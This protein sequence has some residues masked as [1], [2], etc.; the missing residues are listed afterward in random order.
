MDWSKTKTIFIFTFLILNIFL[1]YHLVE[2]RNNS[3]LDILTETS[4]EEKFEVDEITYVDLPK[5]PMRSSFVTGKSKFFTEDEVELLETE[6]EQVVTIL[7]ETKLRGVFKEPFAF[8]ETN[9]ATR[10]DQIIKNQILY[11]DQYVYWGIN[12]ES[13]A[14]IYFQKYDGRIIFNNVSGSLRLYLNDD[15]EIES[16]EQTYIDEMEEMDE[17]QEVI[18]ALKALEN[19]YNLN[20]LQPGSHV[21]E[22]ELGYITLGLT[23]SHVLIPTWH[24]LVND[25]IDFYVNA[26]EGHIISKE[27]R[28]LE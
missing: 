9:T 10:L 13:R 28:T 20:E 18:F 2:K 1:G 8:P 12:A 11:G 24:I 22:V 15:N 5:D 26:F 7:D 6:K 25:E 14:L 19:L 23:A 27:Y 17:P 4:I 16:Y 3:Q 21:S